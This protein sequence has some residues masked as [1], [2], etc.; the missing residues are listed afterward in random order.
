M[1]RSG[2]E[3]KGG[4]VTGGRRPRSPMSAGRAVFTPPDPRTKGPFG[5][6]TVIA[7]HNGSGRLWRVKGGEV[8]THI[9]A[10]GVA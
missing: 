7:G 8:D 1:E 9:L 2:G 6:A 3:W 10:G 5:S 4:L